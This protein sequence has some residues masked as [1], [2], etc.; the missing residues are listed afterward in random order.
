MITT[1]NFKK[2]LQ[3]LGFSGNETL[4]E[5]NFPQFSCSLKVDFSAKKLIYPD[6]IIGRDRNDGFNA[7]ENFV[8][9][10]CVNRLLEKGYRLNWKKN[11][12]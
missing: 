3:E 11:G 1:S 2:M 7:P 12:I 9:F 5:K 8:V 10:E 6:S 4:Y